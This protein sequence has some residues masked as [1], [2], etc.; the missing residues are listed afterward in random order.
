[1]KKHILILVLLFSYVLNAQLL[2][3]G[4]EV[5]TL[6]I[7]FKSKIFT[8]SQH[9][10][11]SKQN[12]VD[13]IDNLPHE[14]YGANEFLFIKIKG[15]KYCHEKGN[16]ISFTWCDCN[17]YVCYSIKKQFFYLLGGFKTNDIEQFSKE[18]Y[19]SLFMANW[20]YKIEDKKLSEFIDYINLHKVKKAINCFE[21]CTETVD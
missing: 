6:S 20:K 7:V 5:D 13:F 18:Y 12:I 10:Y 15:K 3:D 1:M 21:K 2:S 19:S 8:I 11:K 17:F 9:E 16:F 4:N 14:I